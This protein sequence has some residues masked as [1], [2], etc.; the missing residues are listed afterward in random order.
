MAKGI[1]EYYGILGHGF[2]G[3]FITESMNQSFLLELNSIHFD[4]NPEEKFLTPMHNS[5]VTIMFHVGIIPGLLILAPLK[6]A[7]Q[8][9]FSYKKENLP[10]TM[11]LFL[12]F[13]GF[14]VWASFNV[15][16]ELPH[17][18]AFF[19]LMYFSVIYEFRS[20]NENTIKLSLRINKHQNGKD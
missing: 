12:S 10:E 9:V 11:F 19:W 3:P 7:F 4:V 1:I 15:I 6:N 8:S 20:K 2:G 13:V 5:F 16:L 17:S 14:A 18:S